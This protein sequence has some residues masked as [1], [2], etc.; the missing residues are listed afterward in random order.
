MPCYQASGVIVRLPVS[1]ANSATTSRVRFHALLSPKRR[2]FLTR[3]RANA[4]AAD[5]L[6]SDTRQ[7]IRP[8]FGHKFRV[9]NDVKSNP[10]ILIPDEGAAEGIKITGEDKDQSGL[11]AKRRSDKSNSTN[12]TS[13]TPYNLACYRA[14]AGNV[15]EAKQL[16]AEAFTLDASLRMTSLDDPDLV[17]VWDSFS[18]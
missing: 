18:A 16:L 8:N 4:A 7:N 14:V 5:K 10:Y 11:I 6:R 17:G 12:A 15:G 1:R 3:S 13:G 2:Q 9:M